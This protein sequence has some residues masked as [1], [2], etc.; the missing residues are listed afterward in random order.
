[1]IPLQRAR[2]ILE[3]ESNR[4]WTDDAIRRVLDLLYFVARLDIQQRYGLAVA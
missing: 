2:A 1:M 3:A 4:E